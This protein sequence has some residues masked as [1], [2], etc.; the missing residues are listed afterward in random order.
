MAC[1]I[2]WTQDAL[3]DLGDILAYIADD[4]FEIALRVMDDITQSVTRL[5]DFPHSGHPLSEIPKS[6]YREV[7]VYS[8]RVIYRLE[9]ETIYVHMVIH[10]A[11]ELRSAL[12]K[13]ALN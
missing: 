6:P 12:K 7:L 9:S 1:E 4:S 3:L 8:Y 11:R 13:R 5:E 10:G 2:V